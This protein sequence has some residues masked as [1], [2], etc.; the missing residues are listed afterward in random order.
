MQAGVGIDQVLVKTYTDWSHPG[1]V[2]LCGRNGPDF[3][4]LGLPSG[5]MRGYLGR[6]E[7]WASRA[8][9]A[10]PPMAGAAPVLGRRLRSRFRAQPAARLLW[11]GGPGADPLQ[12]LRQAGE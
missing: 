2:C 5:S 7:S 11:G 10:Q 1:T 3:A 9:W 12:R 6:A 4:S 8:F